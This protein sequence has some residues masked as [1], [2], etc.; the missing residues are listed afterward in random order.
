MS[1]QIKYRETRDCQSYVNMMRLAKFHQGISTPSLE[2]KV[3]QWGGRSGKSDPPSFPSAPP[4]SASIKACT[5]F[6]SQNV[7]FSVL[8]AI[9]TLMIPQ[10]GIGT[11]C[12]RIMI[13][14]AS[15]QVNL[16]RKRMQEVSSSSG[17]WAVSTNRTS[18]LGSFEAALNLVTGIIGHFQSIVIFSHV[19]LHLFEW[20]KKTLKNSVL[21]WKTVKYCERLH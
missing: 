11:G 12:R 16:Y 5:T 1:P 10:I 6:Q 9:K 3:N 13:W 15:W 19:Y 8:F 7:W 14:E 20:A 4:R 2:P 18:P 21:L 17:D